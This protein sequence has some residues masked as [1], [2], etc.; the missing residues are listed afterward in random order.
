MSALPLAVVLQLISSC[1]PSVAPST[2]ASVLRTESGF[3]PN[4]LHVNG[5]NGA[6]IHP[7]SKEDAI[8]Q[9]VELIVVQ[10]K[11]VDLGLGQI[12]SANLASLGLT[13]AD[14]LDP[15][16]NLAAASK[17]LAAGY[18]TASQTQADRQQA[19]RA[20]LSRYNTGD[21]AR[22]IAN[23]YVDKVER[24]AHYL[25]PAIDLATAAPE[26]PAGEIAAVTPVQ[27]TRLPPSW[28][29]F[30]TASTHSLSAFAVSAGVAAS[31]AAPQSTPPAPV[32]GPANP[33]MPVVLRAGK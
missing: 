4:T 18:V 25:V 5:P 15:C 16:R 24:S 12:N 32:D 20:A 31:P 10:R 30:G 3:D 13:V 11:S 2:M 9:A 28:D 33:A 7:A 26:A 17:I 22:G 1:A 14:A 29:V 19:L 27:S 6:D 8:V 23:G 21:P